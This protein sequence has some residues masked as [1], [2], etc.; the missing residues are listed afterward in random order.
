MAPPSRYG[1]NIYDDKWL[2]VTF[3]DKSQRSKRNRS[4]TAVKEIPEPIRQR[5]KEDYLAFRESLQAS[6]QGRLDRELTLGES[7]LNSKTSSDEIAKSDRDKHASHV[8]LPEKLNTKDA[9]SR[10]FDDKRDSLSLSY[11]D[12]VRQSLSG[13]HREKPVP[14]F[15]VLP[16]RNVQNAPQA[17]LSASSTQYLQNPKQQDGQQHPSTAEFEIYKPVTIQRDSSSSIL[18]AKTRSDI[19]ASSAHS[20]QHRKL[21]DGLSNSSALRRSTHRNR[22]SHV[23]N[24]R[25]DDVSVKPQSTPPA[26]ARSSEDHSTNSQN[27]PQQRLLNSEISNLLTTEATGPISLVSGDKIAQPKTNNDVDNT[28]RSTSSDAD[29]QETQCSPV[30]KIKDEFASSLVSEPRIVTEPGTREVDPIDLTLD[31]EDET[32]QAKGTETVDAS[33]KHAKVHEDY[34]QAVV[35]T[36]ETSGGRYPKRKGER[37]PLWQDDSD[38]DGAEHQ[39]GGR[40]CDKSPSRDGIGLQAFRHGSAL[41]KRT[42]P[43]DW[44]KEMELPIIDEGLV[45]KGGRRIPGKD[46]KKRDYPMQDRPEGT[47]IRTGENDNING[48]AEEFSGSVAC[49][50][51]SR[52]PNG[53]SQASIEAEPTVQVP[54]R[55]DGLRN[56]SYYPHFPGH[57][58]SNRELCEQQDVKKS[59]PNVPPVKKAGKSSAV[60]PEINEISATR[61]EVAKG[62]G[63]EEYL[64]VEN[65]AKEKIEQANK[66]SLFIEQEE[67]A[68]DI[69]VKQAFREFESA[70]QKI[71]RNQKYKEKEPPKMG[72]S[73]ENAARFRRKFEREAE[74]LDERRM[75]K[76]HR[77]QEEALRRQNAREQMQREE[78]PNH[79]KDG[80]QTIAIH[81]SIE[82]TTRKGATPNY[83]PFVHVLPPRGPEVDPVALQ[84]RAEALFAWRRAG[85]TWREIA[86]KWYKM[87]GDMRSEKSLRQYHSRLHESIGGPP[88]AKRQKTKKKPLFRQHGSPAQP[89]S[90]DQC[91]R[92]RK[93]VRFD[94]IL[95]IKEYN[96]NENWK[97]ELLSNRPTLKPPST[98]RLPSVGGGKDMALVERLYRDRQTSPQDTEDDGDIELVSEV[99]N[100]PAAWLS[101][102]E[103]P[104][105]D[106]DTTYWA[107]AVQRKEWDDEEDEHEEPW[108]QCGDLY[109]SLLEAEL[110]AGK[111]ILQ[112]RNAP[113]SLFP[114]PDEFNVCKDADGL[115]HYFVICGG[116]SVRVRVHRILR[117]HKDGI[118]P[119]SKAGWLKKVVYEVRYE[120]GQE[121]DDDEDR[122]QVVPE[123]FTIRQQANRE[124]ANKLIDLSVEKESQKIEDVQKRIKVKEQVDEFL[125]SL[126]EDKGLFEAEGDDDTDIK[127]W[128][129]ERTLKGPRNI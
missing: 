109:N 111:E 93:R 35:S 95:Q 122:V 24:A 117:T 105:T 2:L 18:D 118:L 67:D 82:E 121:L 58:T 21:T 68:Q 46:Q 113:H 42:R 83:S 40:Q 12:Y 103:S 100:H 25:A 84:K 47:R 27:I 99:G 119:R 78:R 128:V 43:N 127:V 81:R 107:F 59:T 11:M 39:H 72:I 36:K 69:D 94:E 80:N 5:K 62:L 32:D 97:S 126:E 4:R 45:G 116:Y 34:G 49:R 77:E 60:A 87:T 114:D 71:E 66:S 54:D 98:P 129:E 9:H 90:V 70:I 65:R 33:R 75:L 73:D 53:S 115:K 41:G 63:L 13:L 79:A 7:I 57:K 26:S 20:V 55:A 104:I 22:Y 23:K 61:W 44:E 15:S 106:A 30:V 85:L 38:S 92:P 1:A 14:K 29:P 28:V 88:A 10:Y 125:A 108:M 123:L 56:I 48:S 50:N 6:R 86:E 96:P 52:N 8:P 31:S 64:A 74:D 110:T 3:A 120:T 101:R 17:S 19:F 91:M 102:E 76:A 16:G 51:S 112:A 89:I 37:G 124:A